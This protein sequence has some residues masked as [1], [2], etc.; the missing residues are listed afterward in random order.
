MKN[1]KNFFKDKEKAETLL[2]NIKHKSVGHF[3]GSF[4]RTAILIIVLIALLYSA[5]SGPTPWYGYIAIIATL[6]FGYL[7]FKDLI[8]ASIRVFNP[9]KSTIIRGLQRYG[10]IYDIANLVYKEKENPLYE[11]N[12]VIVGNNLI[13][14]SVEIFSI[15]EIINVHKYIHKTNYVVDYIGLVFKDIYGRQQSIKWDEK[16]INN[17][18]K[19]L[20]FRNPNITIGYGADKSETTNIPKS[21]F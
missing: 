9:I 5:S 17:I 8:E 11:G 6:F 7:S 10:D 3:I 2:K 16:E 1:K 12:E 20:L 13:I 19:Y 14:F 15:D 4:I 21:E 18:L